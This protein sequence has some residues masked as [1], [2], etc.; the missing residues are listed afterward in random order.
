MNN[1]SSKWPVWTA[2]MFCVGVAGGIGALKY[3]P[4]LDA[5]FTTPTKS[6]AVDQVPHTEPEPATQFTAIETKV[7][8]PDPT[9]D[10][11]AAQEL[12]ILRDEMSASK[13]AQN[14][15]ANRRSAPNTTESKGPS[16]VQAAETVSSAGEQTLAYWN[17]MNA[18]MEHEAALRAAPPQITAG[19]ALSFVSGETSAYQYAADAIRKLN[20][21]GVDPDVI[22]LAREIVGWY[23]QGIANSHAAESLLQSADTASRQGQPGQD[24]QTAEKQHREQCLQINR[25]GEQLRESLSRKYGLAFPKLQ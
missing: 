22:S 1:L 9:A 21:E 7:P 3:I 20:R 13:S 23:R 16:R 8:E 10:R 11:A 4:A 17:G 19:N 25:H 6:T 14:V 18:I 12:Q 5:R 15:P 2:T 24:W